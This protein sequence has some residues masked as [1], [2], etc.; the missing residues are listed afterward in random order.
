MN[1]R[2][3][4][5]TPLCALLWAAL[6]AASWAAP[7]SAAVRT[8]AGPTVRDIIEFTR[9]SQPNST[10]DQAIQE[11]VSPDGRQAFI[12]TRKADVASD[13]NRYEIQLLDLSPDRL[14]D[15]RVRAPET[16]YAFEADRDAYY[17][18]PAIQQVRWWDDGSLIF[19]GRLQEGVHQLYRLVLATRELVQLTRESRPVVSY[20]AS[21]DLR[22]LVYAVQVPNP[23]M[24]EGAHSIVIG[25]QSFWSVKFGQQRL[26]GQVRKY[27]YYVADIGSSQPPR[28]LGEPFFGSNYASPVVSISPDGR[29]ALLPRY[30][31]TA[32]TLE[33]SRQ[34]P[35][36]EALAQNYGQSLREDPLSYFS[37]P[38]AFAARRMV[39]WRLDDAHEQTVVDAPDDALPGSDQYRGD[40]L[41]QGSG[42]SVILAGT[43]LP[44]AANGKTSRASHI[45]EYWPDSGRWAV[46][47]Q[48]A[49]RAANAKARSDGFEVIDNGKHRRFRHVEGAGWQE[50]ANPT[51]GA[52]NAKPS[53][54]SSRPWTLGISEGL[55]QPPDVVA[56]GPA[57]QTVRL[58]TLNPQFDAGAWGAMKPY[59][60]RD[61]KGRQWRGG[62]LEGEGT[63]GRGQLPLVIQ[64]YAFTPDRFYLD[65]PNNLNG[66]TSAFPGRAFVR[67]GI[68]VLAMA[69]RPT[70]GPIT[71]DREKLRLFNE[72]IRGAVDAL[73]KAGR[74]DPARVGI[75]GWS[76]TGERVLNLLTFSDLPI[77]AATLAD[78]DA[79]TLFSYT[80]TYGFGSWE[81]K[82]TLNQGTPFGPTLADWVRNDP[83]LN[84]DCVRAAVR[85][86]S[87]G[88]PVY[89]NYDLYMMLRRQ[90]RPVEMVLIPGG[91]HSLATPSE[92]MVSLQGNV[93]WYRFWLTGQKRTEPM[94]TG[95]TAASLQAQYE[96]WQQMEQMKV[97]VDAQPRCARFNS[98]G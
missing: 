94:L 35:M 18:D 54:P 96:S 75:I 14:A 86:E 78:G 65:G 53:V 36:L 7:T 1:M 32:R 80:V 41:W 42:A 70:E 98:L 48:L 63:A 8:P 85:I 55:N 57:G 16:V 71:D 88:V 9:L 23:P 46:V 52:E 51:G 37:S 21:R 68:L 19:M 11:Q 33:W 47:A 10:D 44:V 12:V 91:F 66:G 69:F 79:N 29:W 92:R 82:E 45:I 60:W 6:W 22:R 25:N 83:A 20:A 72:G 17:N 49:G 87:Y 27:R 64:T 73:V 89:N 93:D 90:Y 38:H 40:R 5:I 24:K 58:T 74:V 4:P 59:V 56:T 50:V 30:E 28:P 13:R 43:Y 62:L 84:T 31:S 26:V 39:A 97:K 34:Y 2:F 61:A 81:E 77:R 67:E 76:T 15:R 95:E 3:S